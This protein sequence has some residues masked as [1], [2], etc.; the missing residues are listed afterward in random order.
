MTSTAVAV[1]AETATARVPRGSE[2]ERHL[3][4]GCGYRPVRSRGCREGGALRKGVAVSK[5]LPTARRR[6]SVI[7]TGEATAMLITQRA[8]T[9]LDLPSGQRV[10]VATQR[11]QLE[12]WAGEPEPAGLPRIWARKPM[13]AVS[14]RPCCAELAVVA[15]LGAAG[16]Q[17]A[18]V[19]AFGGFVRRQWFPAPG[20]RTMA[21]A[22]AASWAAEIFDTVKAANGGTLAGFFD[23]FAWREPSEVL[24]CEVKVGPDRIQP[25]QR[26][27]LARAL[28]LRPL[29]EFLIIEMPDPWQ[30]PPRTGP[31]AGP[32][33]RLPPGRGQRPLVRS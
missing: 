9:G 14:G 24:F 22:G 33:R 7:E 21:A 32:S 11:W 20:F 10:A 4:L 23:V 2:A 6:G 25:S 26:Q 15:E 3:F 17:G 31:A 16:W 1:V 13:V 8:P 30:E 18:W 29:G 12:W 19:S 27:F 5:D 28:R